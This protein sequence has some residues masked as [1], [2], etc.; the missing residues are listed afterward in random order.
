MF[1]QCTRNGEHSSQSKIVTVDVLKPIYFIFNI[2]RIFFSLFPAPDIPNILI[3]SPSTRKN[4]NPNQI[5]SDGT[6]FDLITSQFVGRYNNTDPRLLDAF[7]V[8][9][10]K[11]SKNTNL[12]PDKFS[13]LQGRTMR[14][15]LFNYNPYAIWQEVVRNPRTK[16][17]DAI[18]NCTF[19]KK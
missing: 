17:T 9:T 10:G 3:I 7:D 11:F 13:K 15:A 5:N 4:T 14:I 19:K 18:K 8:T 12:F 6:L 16:T 1:E 2:I